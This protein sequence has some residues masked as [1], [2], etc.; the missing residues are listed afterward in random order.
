MSAQG[1]QV[2]QING[3]AIVDQFNVAVIQYLISQRLNTSPVRRLDDPVGMTAFTGE[4]GVAFGIEVHPHSASWYMAA[5]AAL[6]VA[7]TTSH[8]F[9]PAFKVSS[10]C[11]SKL[12]SG[13]S[14]RLRRPEPSATNRW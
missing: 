10:T 14:L 12:S 3:H 9:R 2:D 5:G 4:M 13:S 11:D 8:M 1:R 6:T 7:R